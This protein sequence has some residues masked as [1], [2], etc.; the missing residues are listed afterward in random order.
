MFPYNAGVRLQYGKLTACTFLKKKPNTGAS[1][2]KN[3]V[4]KTCVIVTSFKGHTYEGM[5]EV[6]IN[7]R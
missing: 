1:E 2:K 6:R 7:K 4:F 5:N 3:L